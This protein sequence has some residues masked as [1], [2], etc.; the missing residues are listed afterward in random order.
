[1]M[2]MK[3]HTPLKPTRNCNHRGCQRHDTVGLRIEVNHPETNELIAVRL[4]YCEAH[5][6][7]VWDLR[8]IREAI[9][10]SL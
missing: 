9:V 4:R 7:E 8:F 2:G 3:R 5:E 6:P 1:M 10:E